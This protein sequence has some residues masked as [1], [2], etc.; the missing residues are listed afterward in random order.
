MESA[1]GVGKELVMT[2]VLNAPRALVFQAW[3]NPKHLAQ[4]WGPTHFTNPVCEL[5][6]RPGGAINIHMQAPDGT[7]YPMKGEY[8]EVDEPERLVYVSSACPNKDGEDQ[9]EVFTTMTLTEEGG[10]TTMKLVHLITKV[11]PGA[12]FAIAGMEE[13]WAQTLAGLEEFLRS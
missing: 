1:L 5:D 4:W 6:V 11:G 12:E 9:L 10:K 13:G 3:T 2:R 7:V 8:R